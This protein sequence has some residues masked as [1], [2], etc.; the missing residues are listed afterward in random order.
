MYVPHF[1]CTDVFK[2]VVAIKATDTG[3][4]HQEQ[5]AEW[6]ML[7]VEEFPL[8]VHCHEA[9]IMQLIKSVHEDIYPCEWLMMCNTDDKFTKHVL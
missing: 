2:V 6:W 1:T 8:L 7:I 9:T 4:Q 5:L 3:S